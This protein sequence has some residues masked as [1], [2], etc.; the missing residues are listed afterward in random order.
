[1]RIERVTIT[2]AMARKLT[3]EL[4]DNQRKLR[5]T[6]VAQYARDMKAGDWPLTGDTIKIDVNG[7]LIDGQHRVAAIALA[8]IDV[9]MFVAYDVDPA[10]MPVLDNGLTRKFGDVLHISGT[11]NRNLTGAIVR[12]VCQFEAKNYT[13]SSGFG[14][15]VPTNSEMLTR[16]EADVE[17]FQTSTQRGYDVQRSRL[18]PGG[19]AGTAFFLFTKASDAGTDYAHRFFDSLLSGANLELGDPILALRNRV[20]RARIERLKSAEYLALYVRT[21]NALAGGRTLDTVPI[22][23]GGRTLSNATFP[24]PKRRPP[25]TD[26]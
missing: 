6:K 10:V 1:M 19:P 12:Y 11:P 14:R 15:P 18:T 25:A 26:E 23:T 24:L 9:E 16:F 7:K 20:T 4:A 17:L 5:E 2:P 13:A 8:E 22:V 21:W 3:A